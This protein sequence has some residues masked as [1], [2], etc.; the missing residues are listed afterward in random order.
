[1][2][3]IFRK[4]LWKDT[5]SILLCCIS[6][7]FLG[8]IFHFNNILHCMKINLFSSLAQLQSFFF[9]IIPVDE[10]IWVSN[11]FFWKNKC[12]GEGDQWKYLVKQWKMIDADLPGEH[13]GVLLIGYKKQ[14]STP[15]VEGNHFNPWMLHI[16]F[17]RFAMRYM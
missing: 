15:T 13:F 7:R 4:I 2:Q 9:F 5:V 14:P 1:M 6:I 3:V 17:G 10:M 8:K 16:D 11:I 12:I